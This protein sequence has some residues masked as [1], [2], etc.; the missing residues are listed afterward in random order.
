M[1]VYQ[2]E[3]YDHK[4]ELRRNKL[5]INQGNAKFKEMA[6]TYGLANDQRTRH[7]T[8]LDYN[9]DGLL[10]LFILNQPPNPGSYSEFFGTKLLLPEYTSRLYKNMGGTFFKDVTEE[11]GLLKAGFPNGVSASDLNNDG[12]T[13]LH[14]TNDF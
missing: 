6:E 8:F 11:A 9:N 12:W 4:P 14:V 7:A 5:Y 3:L 10:D 13:D 1:K 2:N